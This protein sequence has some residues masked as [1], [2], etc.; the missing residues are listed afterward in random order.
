MSSARITVNPSRGEFHIRRAAIADASTIRTCLAE[1]F[2]P[3]ARARAGVATPR[4]AR[5]AASA[6]AA[7]ATAPNLTAAIMAAQMQEH[8]RG[9]ACAA[10]EWMLFPAL[11]LTTSAAVESVSEIAAALEV[12]S[13][14]MRT[15]V[16]GTRGQIMAD[17]DV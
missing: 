15:N 11:A 8:E 12:D 13:E 1:A 3:S 6:M 10:A 14:R 4:A 7:A 17:E 2:E 16:G 9:I 5:L